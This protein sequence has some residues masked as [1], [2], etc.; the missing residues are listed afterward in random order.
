M[1]YYSIRA[2][3]KTCNIM[4]T[5]SVGCFIQSMSAIVMHS[6]IWTCTVPRFLYTPTPTDTNLFQT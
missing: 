3:T 1:K 6:T 4:I 5:L 2:L